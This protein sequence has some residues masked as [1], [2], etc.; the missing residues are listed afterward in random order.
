MTWV[1]IYDQRL[2]QQSGQAIPTVVL[3]GLSCRRLN[4]SC[5]SENPRPT[6]RKALDLVQFVQFPIIDAPNLEFFRRS[7]PLN[8]HK[9]IDL[10]SFV[11]ATTYSLQL[12]IPHWLE[13]ITIQLWEFQGEIN[14]IVLPLRSPGFILPFAGQL[15]DSGYILE[16]DGY[17]ILLTSNTVRTLGNASSGANIAQDWAQTLFKHL[18]VSYPNEIC[19]VYSLGSKANRGTSADEDWQGDRQIALPDLRGR[20]FIGAG[21]V[22]TVTR[23]RGTFIGQDS[24]ILTI[25]HLPSHNHPGSAIANAGTHFHTASTDAQGYHSHTGGTGAAGSHAHSFDAH[26]NAAIGNFRPLRSNNAG[27]YNTLSTS[28]VGDHAHSIGADGLHG[29]NVSIQWAGDHAH[30]LTIT[31]QGLGNPLSLIQRSIVEHY[32][33]SSGAR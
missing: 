3:E 14:P 13:N 25:N 23:T 20:T 26:G 31:S 1:K 10:P 27:T 9:I 22:D 7:I 8:Q 6:W 30:G 12:K 24:M 17:Y 33:I 2:E 15:P 21:V 32:L 4:F 18:W 28:T 16:P 29:H 5:T 19:P 11:P